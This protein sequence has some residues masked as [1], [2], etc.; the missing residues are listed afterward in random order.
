M[1]IMSASRDTNCAVGL[2]DARV[3]RARPGRSRQRGTIDRLRSGPLRVRV[4]TGSDPTHRQ[5][6][7][8]RRGLPQRRRAA[9][10]AEAAR[11][12]LLNQVGETRHPRT[13]ATV[14]HCST[15]TSAW[16]VSLERSTWPRVGRRGGQQGLHQHRLVSAGSSPVSASW[17]RVARRFALQR[18]GRCRS[19]DEPSRPPRA[20]RTSDG[21]PR[22][23]SGLD[24]LAQPPCVRRHR[25][26]T[27]AAAPLQPPAGLS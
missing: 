14:I 13:N 9:A 19:G 3:T 6:A 20:R 2:C 24:G 8:P 11:T 7:H 4:Q 5:A 21:V 1:K 22:P 18:V 10:L 17:A 27:D 12:C 25:R 16:L 23:R 15:A 26:G